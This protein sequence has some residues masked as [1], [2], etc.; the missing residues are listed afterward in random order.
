MI[1]QV[2]KLG[3]IR[4]AKNI[5]APSYNGARCEHCPL[6]TAR[7]TT[8]KIQGT[9]TLV[10]GIAECASYIKNAGGIGEDENTLFNVVLDWNDVTFGCA[11]KLRRAFDELMQE[12][13]PKAVFIITTCV[14]EITG[15]DVDS[16]AEVFR[17][18]YGI[19][20]GVVHTEH[21][22]TAQVSAGTQNAIGACIE[23]M[24][25]TDKDASVNI[26]GQG[27]K[28]FSDTEL[29]KVLKAAEVEIGVYIPDCSVEELAHASKAKWNIVVDSNA[30]LLGQEMEQRFHI[31]YITFGEHIYPQR[32]LEVYKYL[33]QCL[34]K[35][36]P[37]AV[38]R[39][40]E[41]ACGEVAHI[42][43]AVSG[44]GYFCEH[45]EF[46]TFELNA[47]LC[48]LGMVPQLIVTQEFPGKDNAD[49][50]TILQNS[51]PYVVQ[52]ISKETMQT[53]SNELKPDR[54]LGGRTGGGRGR[55]RTKSIGFDAVIEFISSLTGNEARKRHSEDHW[56]ERH[57]GRRFR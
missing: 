33:F 14:P 56:N 12:Y 43:K 35:P 54:L 20:V 27:K 17:S 25:F 55:R 8:Q 32:I 13:E 53:L 22:K 24:K 51:D 11:G 9:V 42:R 3:D 10:L 39:A 16:L 28:D 1:S 26:L 47:F 45:T 30:I 48:E 4:S 19:A 5:P 21:F 38:M 37:A 50:Q 41:K 15:D 29:S 34:E 31:P 46:P 44:T 7:R 36:M 52:R 40:Y 49:L 57:E 23:M 6:H 18:Q 2:K